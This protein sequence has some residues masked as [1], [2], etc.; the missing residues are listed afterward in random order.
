MLEARGSERPRA[1]HSSRERG[2]AAAGPGQL[3]SVDASADRHR[4]LLVGGVDGDARDAL[5]EPQADAVVAAVDLG[6]ALLGLP[7]LRPCRV[8][9]LKEVAVAWVRRLVGHGEDKIVATRLSQQ[10]HHEVR[11]REAG[12]QV[13]SLKVHD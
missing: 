3:T 9:L 13:P 6:H 5:E 10:L 11:A 8:A 4:E 12:V 2:A 7:T 1:L